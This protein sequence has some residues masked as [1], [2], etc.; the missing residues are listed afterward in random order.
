MNKTLGNNQTE[1]DLL[2]FHQ[3]VFYNS[4]VKLEKTVLPVEYISV[5]VQRQNVF[6]FNK[7]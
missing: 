1:F 4:N 2:V 6:P 5:C 7:H 3:E